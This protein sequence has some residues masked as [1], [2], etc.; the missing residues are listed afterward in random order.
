[1]H[2]V[3]VSERR[4]ETPGLTDARVPDED[5]DVEPYL[6]LLVEHPLAHARWQPRQQLAHVAGTL[7]AQPALPVGEGAQG[8]G[9]VNAHGHATARRRFFA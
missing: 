5:V 8:A 7:D 6:A 4:V 2:V 9:D 1:M 3:A